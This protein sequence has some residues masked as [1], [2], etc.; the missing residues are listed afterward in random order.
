MI[1]R[2]IIAEKF[3]PKAE[4]MRADVDRHFGTPDHSSGDSHQIWDYWHVPGL[5]TYLRTDPARVLEKALVDEFLWQLQR[6]A[7]DFLGLSRISRPYLSL[8]VNG[9]GQGLHNDAGNGRWGFVYSLTRWEERLFTGGETQIFKDTPY[10][11]TRAM[12]YPAAGQAFYD[13]IAPRFNQLL[14]FDDRLIHGVPPLQGTMSPRDGRIVIHGHISEGAVH[15]N[16]TLTQ[17]EVDSV[18]TSAQAYVDSALASHGNPFT[19]CI[20]VR[21]T[22]DATGAVLGAVAMNDRILRTCPNAGDPKQFTTD[23]MHFLRTLRFPASEGQ[24]LVTAA[25]RVG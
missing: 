1:D 20:T 25:V 15:T 2:Y 12:S 13:L 7:T 16:G 9:C 5:Y 19:G 14:V 17:S 6:W 23:L 4:C 11:E 10:W 22:V 18:L 3:F 21:L 24:T 8:Y